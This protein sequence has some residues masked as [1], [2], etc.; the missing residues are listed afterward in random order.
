MRWLSIKH[1]NLDEE[2][3]GDGWEAETAGTEADGMFVN[4]VPTQCRNGIGCCS[5]SV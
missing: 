3:N 2:Q 5:L 1:V 4:N